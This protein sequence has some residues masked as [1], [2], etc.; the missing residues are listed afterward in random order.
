MPPQSRDAA[1]VNEL[2]NENNI[3]IWRSSIVYDDAGYV[4]KLS[5][6]DA[7]H[8]DLVLPTNFGQM[9]QLRELYLYTSFTH[10]PLS[11]CQLPS[12][13]AFVL[14]GQEQ[15]ETFPPEFAQLN[16]L[17][18][19]GLGGNYWEDHLPPV[20]W[21]LHQ[22]RVLD[23][24]RNAI[25]RLPPEIGQLTQLRFLYLQQN[26]IRWLPEEITQLTALEELGMWSHGLEPS[27]QAIVQLHKLHA[28]APAILR[29]FP[30]SDRYPCACCG[31]LTIER[32]HDI[33]PICWWA[34][35]G[36]QGGFPSSPTGANTYCLIEA[37]LNFARVGVSTDRLLHKARSP[38]PEE[39]PEEENRLPHMDFGRDYL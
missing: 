6:Y 13:R 23:L 19:L 28:Q 10:F 36:T 8:D 24:S 29:R 17:R 16:T 9:E 7:M 20:L 4:I 15:V 30:Y 39:I 26:Q 1:I 31:Y 35:D 2:F 27:P 18:Y 34:A 14:S 12:L 25:S 11:I 33:C 22:L 37:R 32:E 21:Q 3:D 5:L 38:L